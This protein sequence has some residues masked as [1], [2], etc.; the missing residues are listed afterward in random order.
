MAYK[1]K[2]YSDFGAESD[3]VCCS[4]SRPLLKFLFNCKTHLQYGW[5]RMLYPIAQ[6]YLCVKERNQNSFFDIG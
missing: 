2:L 1:R 5:P 4:L 6:L 3:R